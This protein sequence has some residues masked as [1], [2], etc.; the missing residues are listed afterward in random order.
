MSRDRVV[1][2]R[3]RSYWVPD[4]RPKAFSGMTSLRSDVRPKAFSG[5]TEIR[6]LRT[7]AGSDVQPFLNSR[8]STSI[9]TGVGN[10]F[11]AEST[12]TQRLLP[13][14]QETDTYRGPSP[15]CAASTFA[16]TSGA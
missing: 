7:L 3:A 11:A 10:L 9:S 2:R 6:A 16:T 1:R 14:P 12:T 15:Y 13:T 5:M 4:V 8:R